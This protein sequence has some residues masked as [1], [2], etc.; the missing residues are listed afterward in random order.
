LLAA[1]AAVAVHV[2]LAVVAVQGA[3]RVELVVALQEVLVVSLMRQGEPQARIKTV[4]VGAV[5]VLA[6]AVA[7]LKTLA[8]LTEVAAAAAAVVFYPVLAALV[9]IVNLQQLVLVALLIVLVA[10]A[11]TTVKALLL[12]VAVGLHL[13]VL[14]T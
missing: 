1:A 8:E 7:A 2:T 3:L 14:V 9:V 5:E 6:V 12:A 4:A 13:A 10:T 11:T